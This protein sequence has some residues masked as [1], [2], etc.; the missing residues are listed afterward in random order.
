VRG[1]T[2][3]AS[4]VGVPDMGHLKALKGLKEAF[5][6][7]PCITVYLIIKWRNQKSTTTTITPHE[8]IYYHN[9]HKLFLATLFYKML[10]SN[11]GSTPGM[12]C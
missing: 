9:L 2:A 10:E 3:A 12:C 1:A 6:P 8:K 5:F 7:T 11:I 4:D